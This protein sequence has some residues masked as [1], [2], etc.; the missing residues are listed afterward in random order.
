MNL[1]PDL[2]ASIVFT[3]YIQISRYTS[4]SQSIEKLL[5]NNTAKLVI[6][7]KKFQLKVLSDLKLNFSHNI[8]NWIGDNNG[9]EMDISTAAVNHIWI[10]NSLNCKMDTLN[11]I[12]AVAREDLIT[13]EHDSDPG[14]TSE[15]PLKFP[16][17]PRS[18]PSHHLPPH[19]SYG[20]ILALMRNISFSYVG[21]FKQ[22]GISLSIFT[23]WGI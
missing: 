13:G 1:F 17:Q 23:S 14:L 10:F 16:T 5:L 9:V 4:I 6:L 15:F 8:L 18:R 20:G 12:V 11:Q 3:V 7:F 2:D 21:T 19:H 22:R